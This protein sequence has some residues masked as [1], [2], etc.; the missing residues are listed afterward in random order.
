MYD[1]RGDFGQVAR[2]RSKSRPN[3]GKA[4]RWSFGGQKPLIIGNAKCA[5][6]H[7]V[8]VIAQGLSCQVLDDAA[9]EFGQTAIVILKRPRCVANVFAQHKPDR[10]V[11][12]DK[13]LEV[14]LVVVICG[15]HLVPLKTCGNGQ[16]MVQCH[17][18]QLGRE[19][20]TIWEKA[21]DR[22]FD[23]TF[24]GNAKRYTK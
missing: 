20:T 16:H 22:A 12:G 21:S 18:V 14:V 10:I 19:H 13:P 15:N 6:E 7:V 24:A 9:G 8:G 4:V 3:T 1:E 5:E 11:N 2:P 23:Y 17:R